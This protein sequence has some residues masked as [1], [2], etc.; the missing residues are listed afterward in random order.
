EAISEGARFSVFVEKNLVALRVIKQNI[1][2]LGIENQALIIKQ[3]VLNFIKSPFSFESFKEKF[4]F[5]FLDPSYASKLAGQTIQ[6]LVNFPFL[7]SDSIIIAEHSDAEILPEELKGKN[8]LKKFR[9]KK[10]GNIAVSYYSI[11]TIILG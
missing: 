11:E 9:E 7:K 5:A 6:S 10:Y 4:D 8:S 2:M 1:K 3:D